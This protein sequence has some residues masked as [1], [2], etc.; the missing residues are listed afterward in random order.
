MIKELKEYIKE[1]NLI[2]K[3]KESFWIA[4][5]NWK[6]SDPIGYSKKFHGKNEACLE[7]Y[8]QCVG[9]RS[10]DWPNCEYNHVTISIRILHN[11]EEVGTYIVWFSLSDESL[12]DD[13]L[14]I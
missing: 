10:A 13:F 4:F 12:D 7:L 1:N 14:E 11:E 2:S 3:A 6:K 5:S 8:I 9:L